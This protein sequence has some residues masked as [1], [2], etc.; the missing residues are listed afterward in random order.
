MLENNQLKTE[1]DHRSRAKNYT[2]STNQRLAVDHQ[3][4][5]TDPA[6]T[7]PNVLLPRLYNKII[8]MIHVELILNK[9]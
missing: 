1:G 6:T 7:F 3:Y 9:N 4:Q 5:H 2:A 8:V